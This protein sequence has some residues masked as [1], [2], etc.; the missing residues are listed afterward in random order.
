MVLGGDLGAPAV[1]DHDGLVRLDDDGGAVDV[2]AG[3][4]LVAQ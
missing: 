2:V 4:E 3:R 1:L